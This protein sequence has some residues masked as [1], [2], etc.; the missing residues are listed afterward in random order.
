MSDRV[1]TYAAAQGSV[2]PFHDGPVN[3][4]PKAFKGVFA[5]VLIVEIIGVFPYVECQNRGESLGYGIAGVGFLGDEE[6]SVIVPGK[7]YPSGPEKLLSGIA[8]EK[9]DIWFHAWEALL[10]IAPFESRIISS[11][12][13]SSNSVPSSSAFR[14]SI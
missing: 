3:N 11:R 1:L 7:P 8:E 12:G 9:V 10:N 5:P 14:L 2:T 6:L 13:S 4:V